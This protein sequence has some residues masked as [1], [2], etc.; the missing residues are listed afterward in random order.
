MLLAKQLLLLESHMNLI[1]ILL[2]REESIVPYAVVVSSE[3]ARMCRPR[4][5]KSPD[6]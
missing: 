5:N 3:K 1:I 4:I 2:D 6:Q